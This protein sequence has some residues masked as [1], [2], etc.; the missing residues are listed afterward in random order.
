MIRAWHAT[1]S[2]SNTTEQ[3]TGDKD[4]VR[5]GWIVSLLLHLAHLDTPKGF[6]FWGQLQIPQWKSVI[7]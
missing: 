1:G 4:R 5:R 6:Y 2:E 3:P 7:V